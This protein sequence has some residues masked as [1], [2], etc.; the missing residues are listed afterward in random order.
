M[1]YCQKAYLNPYVLSE[2]DALFMCPFGKQAIS[3]DYSDS[4]EDVLYSQETITKV[5]KAMSAKC[6]ECCEFC[7]KTRNDEE[8]I[9][10]VVK[11]CKY[12]GKLSK[13]KYIDQSGIVAQ[14]C[15]TCQSL[16]AVQNS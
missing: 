5:E 2:T 8:L 4:S 10:T 6:D 11:G 16:L 3:I 12:I 7:E 15:N 1:Y 13:A 9:D 14:I